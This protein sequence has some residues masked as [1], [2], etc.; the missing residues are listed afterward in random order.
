MAAV[1]NHVASEAIARS[2]PLGVP[3]ADS[4]RSLLL[5]REHAVPLAES[6]VAS[7]TRRLS[8]GMTQCAFVLTA[9]VIGFADIAKLFSSI[10]RN[11]SVAYYFIAGMVTILL[12]LVAV[13]ILL[14]QKREVVWFYP[15]FLQRFT[16]IRSLRNRLQSI[17]ATVH[18]N[19]TAR[20]PKILT[21]LALYFA[22]WMMEFC[23]TYILLNACGFGAT[24]QQ[25]LSIEAGVSLM[26][27]AAFFLPAGIGI[28]ETGYAG[29]I[30]ALG[31]GATSNVGVFLVAKRVRDIFWIALGYAILLGKGVI[32]SRKN[33]SLELTKA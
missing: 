26:R 8:L 15:K 30:A 1:L 32:P 21:A 3:I 29:I 7:I 28:Q 25:A 19:E 14:H 31:L 27:L 10:F 2:I 22:I 18:T 17:R 24:A 13:M 20:A 12:I 16:I 23:E 33:I 5:K 6:V 11:E 4:V 9:A